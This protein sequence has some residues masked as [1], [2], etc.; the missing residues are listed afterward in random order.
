MELTG[1]KGSLYRFSQIIMTIA[2]LNFLWV[3]F[4]L[5]GG[6]ILGIH[7]STVALFSSLKIWRE[8]SIEEVNFKMYKEY[9]KREFKRSN[10]L[11]V[12]VNILVILSIYNG[13]IVY[14]NRSHIHPALT[15]CYMV[16]I[17]LLAVLLIYIYPVYVLFNKKIT[18]T[19]TYSLIIGMAN[20]FTTLLILVLVFLLSVAIYSTSGL[21]IFF[22]VS[23]TSYVIVKFTM[24]IYHKMKDKLAESSSSKTSISM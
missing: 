16:S 1:I 14:I 4:T 7:P 22:G 10:I 20:P 12:F 24:N 6:I 9:Y 18:D 23:A 8:K 5:L 11:G 2:Y 3:L 17:V 21:P 19:F 15:V 13:V